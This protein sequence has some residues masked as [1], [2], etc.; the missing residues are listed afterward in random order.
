MVLSVAWRWLSKV[1][2]CRYK[3]LY[4]YSCVDG[5]IN[6]EV[7]IQ[8]HNGMTSFKLILWLGK[9]LDVWGP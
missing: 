7:S 4:I 8:T 3:T 2:T 1:E 6:N 9:I 5:S